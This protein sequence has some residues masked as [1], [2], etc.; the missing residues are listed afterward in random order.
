MRGAHERVTTDDA[1]EVRPESSDVRAAKGITPLRVLVVRM[2]AAR[3]TLRRRGRCSFR[4]PGGGFLGSTRHGLIYAV[5]AVCGCCS[6]SSNLLVVS[7]FGGERRGETSSIFSGRVQK[8]SGSLML[9]DSPCGECRFILRMVS[10]VVCIRLLK[11]YRPRD[12]W[13][14]DGCSTY[15]KIHPHDSL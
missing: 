1:V 5:I 4:V 13:V 11:N 15:F 6:H 9:D 10:A 3:R 2:A 14:R 8:R 7:T 12:C